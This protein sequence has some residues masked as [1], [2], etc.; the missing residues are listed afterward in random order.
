[1]YFTSLF[2]TYFP[3]L[4]SLVEKLQDDLENIQHVASKMDQKSSKGMLI[5]ING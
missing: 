2:L 3:F 4:E 5:S 1:M